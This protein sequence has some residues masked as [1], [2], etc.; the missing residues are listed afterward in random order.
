MAAVLLGVSACLAALPAGAVAPVPA[1]PARTAPSPTA[2]S[3]TT[4][5]IDEEFADPDVVEVGGVFHAYATNAHGRNIQHATSTDLVR[6]TVDATDVLPDVGAWVTLD[7]PGRVWAPEVFDNGD[8]FTLLY[9][10]RDRA[11]GR[12]CVGSA[13]ASSPDGPFRPV[14]EGPLVCPTE[15]GGAIDASV[16]TENGTRHL[17]WK[18]DGNCCEKDTWIHLQPVSWDG[19]RVTGE[20]VRLIKQDRTWEDRV[21]EAPTLVRRNG[22][23]VLLYSAGDYRYDGYATGWA[24]ADTLTGPYVKGD[25][26]LLTTESFSGAIAGPGGQDVVTGPGGQDRILFHGRG[27]DRS[28]RMLY[29]ADLGFADGR[30]VVRGSKARHEAELARVHRATVRQARDAWGDRAVGHIDEPDSS[31]EFRVFAASP[32][33]HT[34]SVRYGNGSL[35]AAGAPAAAT[36][37]LTVNGADAGAVDYPYTGWDEWRTREVP[38]ELRAGWN[39]VRLAKG[40]RYTEL[41]AVEVA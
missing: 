5:V 25:L 9:T 7:P 13:L 30:P 27:A 40:E 32:G 24:T 20:P 39:T 15:D 19:T 16:H 26:P 18:T 4:P 17:L 2:P 41:D 3:P 28:R 33:P 10:A 1:A 22:R 23:Y 21:V 29:V 6:W 8:G 11:G 12:Q 34:L 31:V 35:D 37:R 14:G 38:V 36:H